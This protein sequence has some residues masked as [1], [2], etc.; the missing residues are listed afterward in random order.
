M[1]CTKIPKSRAN[2]LVVGISPADVGRGSSNR[3]LIRH[4]NRNCSHNLI[5]KTI[6][7]ISLKSS[8][9]SCDGTI[10]DP[11]SPMGLR[12]QFGWDYPS[13]QRMIP[14]EENTSLGISG[15]ICG[16][17]IPKFP[18]SP[19]VLDEI[20][21][22]YHWPHRFFGVQ[23]HRCFLQ[24]SPPKSRDFPPEM[25][26]WGLPNRPQLVSKDGGCSQEF[27]VGLLSFE[28]TKIWVSQ[29]GKTGFT[30]PGKRTNITM[31]NHDV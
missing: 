23:T 21:F 15:W 1:A 4:C 30:R 9:F 8:G 25:G 29:Q 20:S 31:E 22:T 19:S 24:I 10:W 26:I 12:R 18:N 13:P 28:A 2:T 7:K 27:Y 3:D 11:T 16:V 17:Q 6:E 14:C 5:S